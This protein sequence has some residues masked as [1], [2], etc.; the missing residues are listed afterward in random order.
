MST[1]LTIRHRKIGRPL[2]YELTGKHTQQDIQ[3]LGGFLNSSIERPVSVGSRPAQPTKWL[4]L[5][6][7]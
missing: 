6:S 7:V 5:V 4:R 3:S 2:L 1:V